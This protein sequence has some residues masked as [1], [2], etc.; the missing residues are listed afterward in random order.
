[1]ER[2]EL[3]ILCAGLALLVSVV[4]TFLPFFF[5]YVN[6]SKLRKTL[7]EKKKNWKNWCSH[8]HV[9][10]GSQF[11][12]ESASRAADGSGDDNNSL[13]FHPPG[14][15][16]E[17]ASNLASGQMEG[18]MSGYDAKILGHLMC[19]GGGVFL[20]TFLLN[21]VPEVT[22][23]LHESMIRPLFINYPLAELIIGVG[24]FIILFVDELVN[25]CQRMK[26]LRRASSQS[27]HFPESQ[28]KTG[29]LKEVSIDISK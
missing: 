19:F 29:N 18:K 27:D 28:G 26:S 24:F 8:E 11:N 13:Y 4:C 6:C 2:W 22:K 9:E 1:M 14:L 21:M 5:I 12:A 7:T 10:N 25:S 17:V 16:E 15:P 3:K 20:G 23:I